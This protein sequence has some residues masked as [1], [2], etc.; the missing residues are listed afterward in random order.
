M[1]IP[2]TIFYFLALIQVVLILGHWALF[3]SVLFFFP[4]FAPYK[5]WLLGLLGI[6]S[7]S[8]F[9]LSLAEHKSENPLVRFGYII[10]GVWMPTWL[11][12]ILASA[13]SFVVFFISG[14]NIWYFPCLFF[15]A[16]IVLSIYGIINARVLRVIRLRVSIPNLPEYWK[17]KTAVLATDIHLGHVLKKGFAQK[18]IKKINALKPEIVFIPGD[19]FDGVKTDFNALA[20]EFKKVLAPQGIY[21]CSGNHEMF[22]NY[23]DCEQA[24]SSAGIHILENELTEVEGLQ[25]AGIAYKSE[26]MPDFEKI[27]EAL[28]LDRNKASILLKHVPLQLEEV[29]NAGFNL[30]LSGHTHRGQVWPGRYMTKRYYSGFDYGYKILGSLQIY[31]SSGAGTWGPPMRTFTNS[32]VVEITFE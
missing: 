13:A 7:V 8:F 16:A 32:E 20:K 18:V 14:G 10:S 3:A 15:T 24:L 19:F 30:Q 17:G 23:K 12:F 25:I 22:A 1:K 9:S 2:K 5:Y 28:H 29:R 31:I 27:L 11:Y 6:L 4:S 21:F 26:T